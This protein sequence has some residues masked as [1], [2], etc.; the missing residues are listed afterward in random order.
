MSDNPGI[1]P[2]Q[3]ARA[4]A[5][6]KPSRLRDCAG[7][8]TMEVLLCVPIFLAVLGTLFCLAKGYLI[9]ERTTIAVRHAAWH[10][11]RTDKVVDEKR[12]AAMIGAK[13][14]RV[15]S[16]SSSEFDITALIARV[17]SDKIHPLSR[18]VTL[19]AEVESPFPKVLPSVTNT[20]S[21]SVP[22]GFWDRSQIKEGIRGI[23]GN[24]FGSMNTEV[25]GVK[26]SWKR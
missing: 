4:R 22:R 16:G 26:S 6:F 23:F 17:I 11:A 24:Y 3:I 25:D 12:L 14:R 10:E 8:A 20:Q 18:E 5:G 21:F 2:D 15:S 9:N 13:V 19:E 1:E 7:I